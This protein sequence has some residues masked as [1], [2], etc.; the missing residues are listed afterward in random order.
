VC[1]SGVDLADVAKLKEAL[2]ALGY[3]VK[4]G[5]TDANFILA[6]PGGCDVLCLSP[7]AQVQCHGQGYAP[8]ETDLRDM[9]LL[10]ERFGVVLPLSLCRR[11]AAR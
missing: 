5:G 11:P 4:P 8:T 6:D 10:Q 3:R 2:L 1:S 7:D 9:A